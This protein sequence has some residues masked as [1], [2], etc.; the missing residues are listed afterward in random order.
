MFAVARQKLASIVDKRGITKIVYFHTDHF[1]PWRSYDGRAVFG[2][3][4]ARDLEH[5]A[6][7]IADIEYAR[8]L[9]LFYKPH[10]N[11]AM[12][13]GDDMMHASPHDAIGFMRRTP[14]QEAGARDALMPLLTVTGCQ[15]QLH[16]HHENYTANARVT[17]ADT[18]I[19]R[20]LATPEGCSC[21]DARLEFAIRQNLDIIARET[22]RRLDRWFFIHGHWALNASDDADC[23]IVNE[24]DI[25]HRLG[26]RGD[27]T[28]PAGR[29]RVDP[30][31]DRPY[32]C[33]P[34]GLPKGYDTPEAEPEAAAGA[35]SARGE[36][37][38][39]IWA[40]AIKHG[41]TSIDHYSAFV[42]D[43][44]EDL[45]GSAARILKQ[46]YLHNG[47][48][49]VKTHSHSMQ[50]AYFDGSAPAFF[51]HAYPPTR[52]MLSLVFNA[53]ADGGAE[54]EFATVSEVYDRLLQCPVRDT[55][56]ML[57][58]FNAVEAPSPPKVTPRRR[59]RVRFAKRVL[60]WTSRIL[61]PRK[62]S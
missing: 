26:C 20:Y 28:F 39:M 44:A 13:S 14:E 24:I 59:P 9:T 52:D 7:T 46:S 17:A 27:F 1:E 61:R 32:L 15:F 48:L 45:P 43:R 55:T 22:G 60:D 6:K 47:T 54:I 58:A 16:V 62:S 51:P 23:R 49:Y 31:H 12:R 18:D 5:F 57:A 34:V 3:E 2:P 10:L 25:L 19:G 8:R 11:F 33:R 41:A 21:D 56:D 29:T 40:S 4:N 35:G 50:P 38:F 30:R 36:E 42:R 37:K 53:G